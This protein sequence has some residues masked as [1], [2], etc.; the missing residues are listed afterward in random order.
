MRASQRCRDERGYLF[1][2]SCDASVQLLQPQPLRGTTQASEQSTLEMDIARRRS[3]FEASTSFLN[4]Y[5]NRPSCFIS[6]AR[7]NTEQENWVVELASDL[8]K[9]NVEVALDVKD[10]AQ[11]GRDVAR[12]VSR[13]DEVGTILVIGTPLYKKKEENNVRPAG[14][15]GAA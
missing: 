10:N 11:I 8:A 3:I 4:A 7:G 1:C 5:A 13:I 15:I 6:Y 12:F 14:S 2:G 9:A